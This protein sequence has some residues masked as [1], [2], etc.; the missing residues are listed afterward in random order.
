VKNKEIKSVLR[1]VVD[2]VGSCGDLG[3]NKEVVESCVGVSKIN[4]LDKKKMLVEVKR[5]KTNT[6][7]VEYVWNCLLKYEGDGVVK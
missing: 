3:K 1:K 5:I 4:E 2:V 7:L 6:K